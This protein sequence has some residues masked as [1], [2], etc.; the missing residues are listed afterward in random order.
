MFAEVLFALWF[1]LPA[2]FAN[3]APIPAAKLPGLRR[4]NAPLDFGRHF[5]G[6][7]VLGSHKTWRGIVCAIVAATLVLWL[8]QC[9]VRRTGWFV[10]APV[11]YAA[12]P[13]LLL[14]PLLAIGALGGDAVESFLKR[15]R[16]MPPGRP[17]FP[18]DILDH[19]IG[20]ALLGAP[21]VVFSW[22]VYLVVM[23]VWL[24]MTFIVSYL[25]YL[26]Q[27]KERPV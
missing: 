19:I 8:Q 18:F 20:A 10:G 5:R 13:V 21:F 23:G 22:W 25:G 4:L 17:W 14:G 16:E 12:L 2:A 24:V 26:A 27:I 7:R 9:I 15:Q 11:D 6:K 1:F 3:M